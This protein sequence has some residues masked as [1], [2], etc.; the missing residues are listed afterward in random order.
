MRAR[1]RAR[2]PAPPALGSLRDAP[3]DA[4]VLPPA[5]EK[6]TNLLVDPPVVRS[7]R[8]EPPAPERDAHPA[9]ASAVAVVAIDPIG[10]ASPSPEGAPRFSERAM[11][12]TCRLNVD[13]ALASFAHAEMLKTLDHSAGDS[14]AASGLT[15]AV[16]DGFPG[17][18]AG[19]GD[20]LGG[21]A[22]AFAEPTPRVGSA[23]DRQRLGSDALAAARAETHQTHQTRLGED[24]AARAERLER[25]EAPA[26]GKNV[27]RK[28]FFPREPNAFGR[29]WFDFEYA[30]PPD[31][32]AAYED[33]SVGGGFFPPPH[34]SSAYDAE[35][36]AELYG[37]AAGGASDAPFSDARWQT[38]NASRGGQG[39]GGQ[40][41][42]G[43]G[44]GAQNPNPWHVR[45]FRGAFPW[46]P[47][48]RATTNAPPSPRARRAPSA[49]RRRAGTARD[50]GVAAKKPRGV[51][52]V[53][54]VGAHMRGGARSTSKFRGV[55]H[56]CRTGR[57]EAH[58]WEDGKQVYLGGF[59]SEH[60]AA[61]AYD[62]AAVKCR[63][64]DAVTNFCMEDYA[65]ELRGI[66]NVNKEEL[67]LSLRR[68][69]KGFAKGSSKYRG[70]TRHQKGR[71]EARIGQLVGK[72]YRYL[73]L[74]DTE[75]DAAVA[76]DAE[77][78][79]QKGFDAV[80]N[81]DLAEYADEL[82][83]HT[84]SAKGSGKR[85]RVSEDGENPNTE[86]DT[87]P[88]TLA[89]APAR[90]ADVA[91]R[92]RRGEA[93]R[94]GPAAELEPSAAAST[95]VRAFF[96]ETK[97]QG[98]T[99]GGCDARRADRLRESD[100]GGG[101]AARKSKHAKALLTRESSDPPNTSD[102][103]LDV[104]GGVCLDYSKEEPPKRRAGSVAPDEDA[105][106]LDAAAREEVSARAGGTVQALRAM[107]EE[108]KAELA[109]ARREMQ[110]LISE[111]KEQKNKEQSE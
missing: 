107:V 30:P 65:Q 100:P 32:Y 108:A 46:A 93:M 36:A 38:T 85:Q 80:T 41:D 99:A 51:S 72:K 48:T 5:D 56:H 105:L 95:A 86:Q 63:G 110:T 88:K 7:K 19:F 31:A 8:E 25:L 35:L 87:S 24:A 11:P 84:T 34:A 75:E 33:A 101:V 47:P 70:V 61:L 3:E 16:F 14:S 43:Q 89:I 103:A 28:E 18:G 17:A 60:Q 53:G 55:T 82:A 9:A 67:V 76:Y 20:A 12:S 92:A 71:W 22:D 69:S 42:G 77:A 10:R 106:E 91:A 98:D 102:D 1:S 13:D 57:W 44:D 58:I 73:G 83:A 64:D 29:D 6:T 104:V 52:G 111:K 54:G 90:A 27:L 39:D 62:V 94:P 26:S 4:R 81:F 15:S 96:E 68:Q 40:G 79:R 78:V 37:D 23:I 66:A 109:S 2:A 50:L 74:F 21:A 59:D 49:K 45:D 97:D